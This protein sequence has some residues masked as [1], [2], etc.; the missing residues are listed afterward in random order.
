MERIWDTKGVSRL[1]K[2]V[3]PLTKFM[4]T[5]CWWKS[6]QQQQ[7]QYGCWEG[8]FF[9]FFYSLVSFLFHYLSQK[10][11]AVD[12]LGR[13]RDIHLVAFPF[14]THLTTLSVCV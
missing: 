14:I 12:F 4:M 7:R 10:R 1:E 5:P 6:Q 2:T 13:H 11:K 3:E 8:I 9:P